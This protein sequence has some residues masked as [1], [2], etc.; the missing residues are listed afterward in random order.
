MSIIRKM[1]KQKATWWKRTTVDRF[2]KFSYDPP[3]EID[4]RWDDG[5]EEF[6]D[7]QEQIRVPVATIY[8]DREL[9]IGDKLRKGDMESDEPLD[10]SN[11]VGAHEVQ[12]FMNNPNLRATEFLLT[13]IL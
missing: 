7:A 10:P 9:T 6:R 11:V 12:K 4:C 5:G 13:V 8:V 3:V 1:R 2:G